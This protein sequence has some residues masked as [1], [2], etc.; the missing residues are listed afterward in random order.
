[1]AIQESVIKQFNKINRPRRHQIGPANHLVE[2]SVLQSWLGLGKIAANRLLKVLR[3]PTIHVQKESYFN[4]YALEKVFFYLTRHGGTGFAAPGSE[5][6]DKNKHADGKV[7]AQLT[8]KDLEI[9]ATPEFLTEWARASGRS[10]SPVAKKRKRTTG[11]V[12]TAK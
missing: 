9:M 1:M 11:K 3:V 10:V 7:P 8:D 4:L 5:F 12:E 6:K 2:I